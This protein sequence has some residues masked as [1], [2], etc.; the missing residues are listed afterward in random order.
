MLTRLLAAL[1]EIRYPT[2][3]P[4]PAHDDCTLCEVGV[5]DD[6]AAPAFQDVANLRA[7]LGDLEPRK[8]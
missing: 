8:R 2:L 1:H 6:H 3:P 7:R 4:L 5:T